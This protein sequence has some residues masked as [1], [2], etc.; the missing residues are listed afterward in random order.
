MSLRNHLQLGASLYVPATHKS[1][2]LAEIGNGEKYPQLRSVIFCT[3]DA[4]RE[5]QVSE[6]LHNIKHALP[7]LSA[8]SQP[9][10][11]I[12]VRNP[13]VLG[14]CM[15][16]RDIKNIDG[17]VLPKLT[18]NNLPHY[19]SYFSQGDTFSIMPTLETVEVF[20]SREMQNLCAL[21]QNDRVRARV[22]ALR[23]GGNDLL[24][25]LRVRREPRNTI[26]DTPVG[27]V[28]SR[29]ACEFIP[30]GFPLTAPVFEA[31]S[32]KDILRKEV[33]LDLLHGLFGKT[34]IHPDQIADIEE[35]FAVRAHDL[36][37]A[38]AILK[39]DAPA[40]FRM[41]NRMCEPT[42]HSRWAQDIV[43]REQIY[44]V[45]AET[46]TLSQAS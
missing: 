35:G 8:V 29:L 7:R 12:R 19:L 3:E 4:V 44:G 41:G 27:D 38:Q 31:M 46:A 18:A 15:A 11:F 17:F 43:K 6:A 16:M 20:D 24:N 14:H 45:Q 10:R 21:L 28:I 1:T 33:E 22:L 30:A 36:A 32:H 40:V 37:E 13:H 39:C 2:K 23:I 9:M 25:L 26:Y 42:T 5:E 34:A